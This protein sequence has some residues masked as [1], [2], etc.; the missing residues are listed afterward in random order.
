[1]NS[2]ENL[3]QIINYLLERFSTFNIHYLFIKASAKAYKT[4]STV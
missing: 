2:N 3:F 1:M 4:F